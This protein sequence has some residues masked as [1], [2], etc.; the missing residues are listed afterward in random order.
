MENNQFLNTIANKDEEILKLRELFSDNAKRNRA[1]SSTNKEALKSKKHLREKDQ[2]IIR[3]NDQLRSQKCVIEDQRQ[4]IDD[5]LNGR[6]PSS[7]TMLR[8]S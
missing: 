1:R 7:S 2:E 4:K 3:L 6:K 8:P 5:L